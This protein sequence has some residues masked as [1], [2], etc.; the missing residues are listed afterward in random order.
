MNSEELTSEFAK[1]VL[2]EDFDPDCQY[3]LHTT[4]SGF[5]IDR[6]NP[7]SDERTAFPLKENVDDGDYEPVEEDAG[8]TPAK[9][10]N[11]FQRLFWKLMLYPWQVTMGMTIL[12]MLAVMLILWKVGV[13]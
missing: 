12:A 2:G 11:G 4:E 13:H 1:T 7:V 9:L 8:I 3:F 5:I 6:F 10:P